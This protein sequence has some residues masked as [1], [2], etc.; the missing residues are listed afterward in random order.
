MR[1]EKMINV[2]CENLSE[3]V[4]CKPGTTLK[5]LAIEAN[6][7]TEWPIL[8]AIVD[9]QLKELSFPIYNS[10]NIEFIDYSNGDGARCY[11]RSLSFILQK[12][13]SELFP[14][15]NLIID[16]N[17]QS[18]LY[19]ELRVREKSGVNGT[20]EPI[21]LSSQHLSKLKRR[22]E[23]LVEAD[24]P[25]TKEKI[26]S[27][28][29]VEM[30]KA[31]GREEKALLHKLK[32]KF[33]TTVYY[34]DGYADHYYGPLVYSTG[35]LTI[36]DL[37]PFAYGFML[38]YPSITAPYELSKTPYQDKLFD[39]FKE[40]S[41]W[42]NVLGV[43]GVGSINRAILDGRAEELI[44]LSE[45]LHDRKYASIADQLFKRRESLKL[46]LI[47]GPSSSGK[48]STSKRIALQARVLGMNP[49]IIEMDNYFVN[50]EQTPVDADGNYDF[51]VLEAMDMDFLTLQLNQL[52]DGEEV[53]LPKFDFTQG[54]RI[55]NGTKL[56][57]K[58][59]DILIMEGI[60]GLNPRFTSHFKAEKIYKIY[61]SALTSLSLD[62]NNSI[63]TSDVRLL[64]RMVRDWSF[65]GM[66]PEDTLMRWASVRR[67]EINNIFPYQENADIMFNS[68]LLYELPM[69]KYYAEPLL[70]RIA[71]NSPASVE[72]LRLLKFLSYIKELQPSEIAHIPPTSIM[73]EFIGGSSFSY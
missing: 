26:R 28:V 12:A 9:N 60:H 18:G 67:G 24:L 71:P 25:F 4:Y 65:R 22:M 30:F 34:L 38:K 14:N 23:Q 19:A 56:K 52:F 53:E 40:Y 8:A 69:L 42:C 43:R 1:K 32:G 31:N 11:T 49:V 59:N 73:R 66:T 68:A 57:L 39:V 70:R 72:S 3:T 7:K 20:P 35:V 46:V 61:A 33:F 41:N 10:H 5:E 62:E 2:F 15:Y 51:E 54:K 29:A 44:Q 6:V 27:E 13:A 63:S 50:R 58:E 48:T 37:E 17:L 36:F 21:E 45:A 16:Y 64:R 55:F 47:A